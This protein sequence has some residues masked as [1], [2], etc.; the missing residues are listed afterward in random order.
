MRILAP[1]ILAFLLV[2]I[3]VQSQS[4]MLPLKLELKPLKST[5]GA[6]ERINFMATIENVGE[7]PLRIPVVGW[8][9]GEYSM[10]SVTQSD[11]ATIGW[12][13]EIWETFHEGIGETVLL[14]PHSLFGREVSFSSFG[15]RPDRYKISF[16]LYVPR[17]ETIQDMHGMSV[18]SNEVFVQLE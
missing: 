1:P 5:Y 16:T 18:E 8:G 6:G 2:V 14:A 11:G 13:S 3:G 10:F 9:M 4:E 7:A 17:S 12:Q 15:L